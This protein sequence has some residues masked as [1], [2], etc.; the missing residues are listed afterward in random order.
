MPYAI[1]NKQ[2]YEIEWLKVINKINALICWNYLLFCH[3]SWIVIW[4]FPGNMFGKCFV[5]DD[6]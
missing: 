2:K 4:R 3:N 6:L 1:Y 5:Y